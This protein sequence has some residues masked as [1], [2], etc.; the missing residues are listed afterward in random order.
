MYSK[1]KKNEKLNAM[2]RVFRKAK[3]AF[4]RS[5]K[6]FKKHISRFKYEAT[7]VKKKRSNLYLLITKKYA[8]LFRVNAP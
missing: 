7:F 5:V 2:I 6:K 1:T 4:A 3:A 8:H